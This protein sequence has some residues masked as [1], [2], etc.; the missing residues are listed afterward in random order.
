MLL[1]AK[2]YIKSRYK[3]MIKSKEEDITVVEFYSMDDFSDDA[4]VVATR[5]HKLKVN[6]DRSNE[7]C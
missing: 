5:L 1:Q 3:E 6:V 7:Q 2:S 4:C